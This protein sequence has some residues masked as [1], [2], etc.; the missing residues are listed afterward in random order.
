MND[1]KLLKAV[2][3]AG[4]E[5][6]R[7]IAPLMGFPGLELIG[8]T[9][10]LG[11]QNYKIHFKAIEALAEK[12]EPDAIF[13]LMDLA[14]EANALGRYTLFPVD[15]SATVPKEKFDLNLV[16]RLPEIDITSDGR[17][18][19]YAETIRLMNEKLDNSMLKGA[20]VT[21]P[22]TLAALILGA[23]ETAMNAL[24]NPGGLKNL[25]NYCTKIIS[26]YSKMLIEAGADMICVLEPSGSMLS[27]E[28]FEI[29]SVDFVKKI[30]GLCRE[31]QVD[32]IYHVCGNTMHLIE[33][34]V[35]GNVNGLS[36]DSANT[37]VDLAAAADL[38]PDN[39]VVIGNINPTGRIL[40]GSPPSV[41]EE[42]KHLLDRMRAFPNF[43]LS[44]GCDLPKE[45]P[46]KNIDA[47]MRAGRAY[48]M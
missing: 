18:I 41:E 19:I 20:Y 9:I 6:R 31:N 16:D 13:P 46:L 15:D 45:T 33:S 23:D 27:A 36:L 38:V 42:V 29:F 37:G 26:D 25:V 21:G 5:K 4:K 11:Q 1:S 8:S 3:Q 30:T 44:S 7:L 17:A 2:T 24:L 10:K 35:K 47:F 14:V 34:M 39:L 22:Y 32:S 48:Q 28:Q 43:I 12:F 40:S